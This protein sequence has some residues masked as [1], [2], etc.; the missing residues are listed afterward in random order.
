METDRDDFMR[1]FLAHQSFVRGYLLAAT[2]NSHDADDLFQSVWAALW[3]EHARFDL[4]QPFRAWALGMARLEMLKW[5][6]KLARRRELLSDG[7]F[8]SL[9]QAALEVADESEAWREHL[10]SC[11]GKLGGTMREAIRLRYQESF[12]L[13]QIARQLGNRLGAVKMILL[14]ARR[15]LRDCLER[16]KQS[17]PSTEVSS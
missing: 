6:Q 2:G 3:R 10:L 12:S 15:A 1:Q 9:T 4:R 16:Q 5:R 11:V 7:I 14:R 13:D 17:S 8:E